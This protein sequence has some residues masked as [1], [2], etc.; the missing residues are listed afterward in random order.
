MDMSDIDGAAA[1]PAPRFL[2]GIHLA[3]VY[4]VGAI[5][6]SA[7]YFYVAMHALSLSPNVAEVAI[8]TIVV[9]ALALSAVTA[10]TGRASLLGRSMPMRLALAVLVIVGGTLLLDL[11]VDGGLRRPELWEGRC[12]IG[13]SLSWLECLMSW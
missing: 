13:P 1:R 2:V 4:A 12:P 10:L 3:T 7:G 9:V 8:A 6:I 11:W 5:G